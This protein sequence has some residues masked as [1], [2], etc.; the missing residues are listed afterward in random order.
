MLLKLQ[1][2]VVAARLRNRAVVDPGELAG[3]VV[4]YVVYHR[5]SV[6]AGV[7]HAAQPHQVP[8]AV[9]RLGLR[10]AVALRRNQTVQRVVLIQLNRARA[11][12]SESRCYFFDPS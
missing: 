3:R 9:V 10:P 11:L 6:V 2:I 7:V 1:Q 5:L 8:E 4:L 12:N